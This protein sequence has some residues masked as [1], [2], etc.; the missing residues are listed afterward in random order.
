M[1]PSEQLNTH[2]TQCTYLYKQSTYIG[3][4]TYELVSYVKAGCS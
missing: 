3:E 2:Y 1:Y 4:D